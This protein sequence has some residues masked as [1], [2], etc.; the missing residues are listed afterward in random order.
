MAR[1]RVSLSPF[2][3]AAMVSV[4]WAIMLRIGTIDLGH[5]LTWFGRLSQVEG[6]WIRLSVVAVA[7]ASLVC[8]A[9]HRRSSR[10]T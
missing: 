1:H 2:A 3:L 8:T 9:V 7:L 6:A 5:E 4:P 10:D